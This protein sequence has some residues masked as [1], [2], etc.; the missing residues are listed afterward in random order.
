MLVLNLAM[1]GVWVRLLSLPKPSLYGDILVLSSLGVY[2][3]NGD[4][5]DLVILWVIGM[6]GFVVRS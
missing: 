1:A 3:L 2:S 5:V 4:A 6:V